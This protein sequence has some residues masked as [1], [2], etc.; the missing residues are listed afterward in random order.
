MVRGDLVSS[1]RPLIV[2]GYSSIA[3]L[4]DFVAG[5]DDHE[6]D[7]MVRVLLG[8][9]PFPT[10][11]Y[12]F[13]SPSA[14]FTDEVRGYWEHQGIS[15]RPSAKVLQVIDAL[16]RGRL[17]CRSIHGATTLHATLYVGDV[18]A[19]VG[20]SNF[21]H[22][23]LSHQLE[24]DARFARTRE[25]ARYDGLVRI[26]EN[27]W[28]RGQPWDDELCRLLRD[29]L[30]A[31][32]PEPTAAG[33]AG[34]R[35]RAAPGIEP[36]GPAAGLGQIPTPSPSGGSSSYGRTSTPSGQGAATSSSSCCAT[37][38]SGSATTR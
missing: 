21:T 6:H 3:E 34:G 5:W 11:R 8:A 2:A 25:Q 33:P 31:A 35:E 24:P 12:A 10:N 16:E 29:L 18:A 7:G 32:P 37:S 20:S 22:G 38:T 14:A 23:G 15:L 4:V 28:D 36:A 1:P 17:Q 19:T 9:E 26:A 13:A 30:R 27:L